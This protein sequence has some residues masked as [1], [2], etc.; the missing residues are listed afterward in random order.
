M[1]ATEAFRGQ[2]DVSCLICGGPL[3]R[4]DRPGGPGHSRCFCNVHL[5]SWEVYRNQ[6]LRDGGRV[7][8]SWN[9]EEDWARA[10]IEGA[11]LVESPSKRLSSVWEY[12]D[13][14]SVL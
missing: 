9:A 11:P 12:L 1:P 2:W 5:L 14:D 8:R 13:S 4:V 10:Q 3:G 6:L 7:Y